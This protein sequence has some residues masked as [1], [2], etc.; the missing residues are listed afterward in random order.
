[1]EQELTKSNIKKFNT[2]DYNLPDGDSVVVDAANDKIIDMSNM[3]EFD[4][5]QLAAKEHGVKINSPKPNCKKCYGR[6][7]VS[8]D[9]K[10]KLP[11]PC[12]CIFN[13]EERKVMSSQ[14]LPKNRK[15]RRKQECELRKMITR[16][17]LG[18]SPTKKSRIK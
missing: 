5:I 8:V 11:N 17:R 18:K 6:G 7:Y 3:S 9:T 15:Q 12:T 14:L 10:S 16:A 1:M 13:K 4:K 2:I